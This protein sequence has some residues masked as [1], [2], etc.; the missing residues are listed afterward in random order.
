LLSISTLADSAKLSRIEI[1]SKDGFWLMWVS[2]SC[3][4]WAHNYMNS[5]TVTD[6]YKEICNETDLNSYTTAS[7]M[8]GKDCPTFK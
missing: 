7:F 2:L 8:E 4:I 1:L 5:V 3:L 6:E